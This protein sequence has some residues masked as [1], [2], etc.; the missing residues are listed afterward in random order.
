MLTALTLLV[1]G[2]VTI[3]L[4]SVSTSKGLDIQVAEIAKVTGDDPAT[5]ALVQAASL[6]YAPAPGYHRTLRADLVASSLRQVLP[7]IEIHVTGAPRCRVSPGI[8]LVKSIDMQAAAAV[9]LRDSLAGQDADAKF[10]GAL[11]DLEVPISDEAPR[12]VVPPVQG[13]IF[14]G[15]RS[16]PVQVWLDGR[17]YRTVSADFEVAI[18]QRRAILRRAVGPGESLHAG[19]FEVKRVPVTDAR[20]MQALAATELG[21]AVALKGMAA[22]TSITERDVHREVVMRRGDHVTVH[23]I[24]GNVHVKDV[25]IVSA[26]GRM[27][28]RVAV[29]LQ[30]TGRELTATVRGPKSVEVRIK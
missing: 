14:P 6:G 13:S 27:G 18:W 11:P 1:L 21:G 22:G 25:G 5:V 24:K 8:Q 23:V 28:E 17:I 15:I 26:S 3:E 12:I 10:I 29:V 20:G 30:S 4:P 7:G 9:R 2:G 19:L 16:V